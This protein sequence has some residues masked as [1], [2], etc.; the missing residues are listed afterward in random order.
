M[1]FCLKMELREFLVKKKYIGF[2][3]FTE[4]IIY[5]SVGFSIFN[6]FRCHDN[7]AYSENKYELF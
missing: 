6:R 1:G 2:A 3:E 5:V 4:I 7:N